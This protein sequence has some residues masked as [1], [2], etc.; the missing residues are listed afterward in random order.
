MKTLKTVSF[1]IIQDFNGHPS[2]RDREKKESTAFHLKRKK[3]NK[4]KKERKKAENVLIGD[5]NP[6]DN[7]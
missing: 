3:E 7:Q 5:S 6:E 4:M 2:N 1:T